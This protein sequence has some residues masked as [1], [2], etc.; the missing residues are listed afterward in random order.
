MTDTNSRHSAAPA[1]PSQASPAT[2]TEA[3]TAFHDAMAEYGF[4]SA[5]AMV[6]QLQLRELK[7]SRRQ[8]AVS[9]G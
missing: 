2:V 8:Q 4:D 3:E 1:A 7:W 5:E 9:A 6:A